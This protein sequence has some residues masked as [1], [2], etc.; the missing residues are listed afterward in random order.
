MEKTIFSALSF[1]L[2]KPLPI[3]F[4]RRF[5]KA[6]GTLGDR[7]YMAAKYF[8]EAATIDYEM[9][10][11]KPSE[12]NF[13]K[14]FVRRLKIN[15]NLFPGGRRIALLVALR[16]EHAEKQRRLVERHAQVLLD[17]LGQGA[18]ADRQAPRSHHR[19]RQGSQ[20]EVRLHEILARSL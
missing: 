2:A 19:Q 17:V 11:Y 18:D 15:R 6:A 3:H 12:V 4:L 16:P 10:K 13:R 7:Q 9:T 1:N 20:A 14:T 5:A 8:I